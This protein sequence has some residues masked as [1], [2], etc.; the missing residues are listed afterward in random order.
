MSSFPERRPG[1]GW[2][3]VLAVIGLG[4]AVVGWLGGGHWAGYLLSGSFVLL[5]LA[6]GTQSAER[7]GPLVVRSRLVDVTLML[8]FAAVLFVATLSLPAG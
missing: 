5:A 6:R 3:T 1:Q 7:V 8:G 4:V 2:F